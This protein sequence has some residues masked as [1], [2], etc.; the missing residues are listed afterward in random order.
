MNLNFDLYLP[1]ISFYE[2]PQV[3]FVLPKWLNN[4]LLVGE[5]FDR[6]ITSPGETY[7]N[8]SIFQMI[9]KLLFSSN[10]LLNNNFLQIE[11]NYLFSE[12]YKPYIFLENKIESIYHSVLLLPMWDPKLFYQSDSYTRNSKTMYLAYKNHLNHFSESFSNP[13]IWKEEKIE[14]FKIDYDDADD[15][16]YNH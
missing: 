12:S 5:F 14:D 13:I 6:I 9:S 3:N 1:T 10:E 16:Y 2:V 11:E 8:I 15:E 4:Q 7:D